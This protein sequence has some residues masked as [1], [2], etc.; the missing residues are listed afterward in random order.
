[1]RSTREDPQLKGVLGE[2]IRMQP[3]WWLNGDP[4][5]HGNVRSMLPVYLAEK[6]D[7]PRFLDQSI[8]RECRR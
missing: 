2:A 4:R 5:V 3:E 8:A 1:M 7:M 6:A